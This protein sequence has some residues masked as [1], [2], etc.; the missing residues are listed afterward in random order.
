MTSFSG[1]T[2]GSGAVWDIET[3]DAQE[4]IERL[5]FP[6]DPLIDVVALYRLGLSYCDAYAYV[7]SERD[8]KPFAMA[9]L[10][11][12]A[13]DKNRAKKIRKL[14]KNKMIFRRLQGETISNFMIAL[15]R[16][17]EKEKTIDSDC[18]AVLVRMPDF[19]DENVATSNVFKRCNS[20]KENSVYPH[21]PFSVDC[22]V[23]FEDAIF[24]KDKNSVH[25]AYYWSTPEKHVLAF[26]VREGTQATA[27]W[28]FLATLGTI[29]IK[30]NFT[31]STKAGF[32]FKLARPFG[33]NYEIYNP[34][35]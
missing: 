4:K 19:Y 8:I 9:N 2:L 35:T 14:F 6:Q 11:T 20:I 27:P 30:G 24:H 16:I 12:T 23:K 5:R 13:E 31:V 3:I 25:T 15:E 33:A 26:N 18:I 7:K 28:K 21:Q 32:D 29:G 1:Q 10:E 34:G 22:T 17:L